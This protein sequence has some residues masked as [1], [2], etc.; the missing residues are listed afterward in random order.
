MFKILFSFLFGT[1]FGVVVTATTVGAV[2]V[3]ISDEEAEI[4]GNI[5]KTIRN[6]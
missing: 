2:A 3:L 1:L 4:L 5:T 6:M